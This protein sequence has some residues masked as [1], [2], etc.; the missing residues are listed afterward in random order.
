MD[1]YKICPEFS[2][3]FELDGKLYFAKEEAVEELEEVGIKVFPKI[4]VRYYFR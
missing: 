2:H 1:I 4:S 3:C